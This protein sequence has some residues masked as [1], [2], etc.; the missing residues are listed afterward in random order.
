METQT[1]HSPF[2]REMQMRT[3]FSRELREM[4]DWLDDA[5]LGLTVEQKLA[6]TKRLVEISGRVLETDTL[7]AAG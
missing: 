2:L 1:A 6:L 7:E 5:T 4:S 3:T